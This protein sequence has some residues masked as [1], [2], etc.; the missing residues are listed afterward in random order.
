M[1]ILLPPPLVGRAVL[2]GL[3]FL[4]AL[5]S[6]PLLFFA[7]AIV[8]FFISSKIQVSS[9]ATAKMN[10]LIT[11]FEYMNMNSSPSALIHTRRGVL[12]TPTPKLG[13]HQT[14]LPSS[15]NLFF[16]N[17]LTTC[18]HQRTHAT[19]DNNT[20][21]FEQAPPEATRYCCHSCLYPLLL[22]VCTYLIGTFLLA[23]AVVEGC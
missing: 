12:Q 13:P 15:T 17:Y 8:L 1:M 21:L 4:E 19:N 14:L 10:V 16:P 3:F 5:R 6:L 23:G 22:P 7:D 20:F 18:T 2:G 9:L 11:S